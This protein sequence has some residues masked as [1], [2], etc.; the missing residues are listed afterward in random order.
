MFGS[1]SPTV[2]CRRAH[3]LYT[4][5][6][7][8]LPPFVCRRAHVLFTMFGSSLPPV[9]CRRAHVLLMVFGSS[10]PPVVCRRV[11]AERKRW[12]V[13][14]WWWCQTTYA[15][16]WPDVSSPLAY[17]VS[18]TN[19]LGVAAPKVTYHRCSKLMTSNNLHPVIALRMSFDI[20]ISK[21]LS[22]VYVLSSVL[23]GRLTIAA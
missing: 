6:G 23:W 2:V 20:I 15:M 17:I 9:V 14:C 19:N 1:S 16:Q 13:S 18:S 4:M 21:I 7:S 22:N 11:H 3:V 10:L 5:F 8:S 12:R